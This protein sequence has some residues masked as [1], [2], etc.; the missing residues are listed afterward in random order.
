MPYLKRE[1]P[2]PEPTDCKILTAAL[3][4]FVNNGFHNVS[5]HEIQKQANVSIGS[6]YKHFGGKEG[7]AKALYK[8]I[9]NEMDELV[10]DVIKEH[11]S[12]TKQCE[13][14]I[15]LLCGYTETHYDIMAFIFHA[16][17]TEFVPDEPLI[18]NT[19]PFIKI[20]DIVKAGMKN[21]EFRKIDS[22]V[23]ASTI[24]GGVIRMI[25]LR[26]DNMIEEPLP[27]YFETLIDA[28]LNGVLTNN[29]TEVDNKITAVS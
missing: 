15:R 10:D 7:I 16:K 2:I 26:L 21:G 29:K 12:P 17:H 25:Q 23:A 22:W 1:A 4:L 19:I 8:H 24:F 6:I 14:I 9:L 11:Q 20:R 28:S 27:T 3:E 5:V 13:E 18:C